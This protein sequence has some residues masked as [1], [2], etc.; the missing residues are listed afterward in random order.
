MIDPNGAIPN[1]AVGPATSGTQHQV[2]GAFR[3]LQYLCQRNM[4]NICGNPDSAIKNLLKIGLVQRKGA[5]QRNLA[6]L[7]KA[8]LKIQLIA[9][10]IGYVEAYAG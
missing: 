2:V 5:E 7:C 4:K 10:P 8:P 1:N 9:D 3:E 6:L